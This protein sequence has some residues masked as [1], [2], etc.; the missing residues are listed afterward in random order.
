[1]AAPNANVWIDLLRE[2]GEKGFVKKHPGWFL[3]STDD[4]EVSTF[5]T[6][7]TV[8]PNAPR[9]PRARG[10][11]VH[12]V[13]AEVGD[14]VT[15]GRSPE[16]NIRFPHPS[17]SKLHARLDTGRGRLTVTDLGSHNGTWLNG[18]VVKANK[19]REL[20]SRDRVH[21]GSVQTIVLTSKD[22]VEALS[23]LL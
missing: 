20:A 15:V 8:D 16:C 4:A 19:A 12:W 6:T 10:L 3:L 14:L 2:L 22:A 9:K 21:F 5:G 1:M 17:I 11:A 18:E 7:L 13:H 23:P